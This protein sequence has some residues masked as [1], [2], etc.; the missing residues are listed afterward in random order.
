MA[1]AAFKRKKTFL[2]QSGLKFKEET[3]GVLHFEHNFVSCWNLDTSEG[4]SEMPGKFWNTG[5][6]KHREDQ[7]DLS[8][9]KWKSVI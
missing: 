9:E 1:K 6:E 2:Q 7:L 4:T 5:S 3:S 8:Y